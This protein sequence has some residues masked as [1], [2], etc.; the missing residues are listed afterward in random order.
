MADKISIEV[1]GKPLDFKS[2][3]LTANDVLKA[4][5]EA[6]IPAAQDG[7][8]KISLK[9]DE[10]GKIYV[11]EDRIDIR[12]DKKFSIGIAYPFTVNGQSFVSPLQ[13]L[14]ALDIIKMAQGKNLVPSVGSNDWKLEGDGKFFHGKDWV[15]LEQFPSLILIPDQPT[16]VA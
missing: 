12:D 5:Q 6:D 4:A 7:I 1:E 11:G 13:K 14:I 3:D 15:D 10:S 2:A 9:G 8:E 16:P